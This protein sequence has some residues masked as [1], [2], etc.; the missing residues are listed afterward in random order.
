MLMT[1]KKQDNSS[2]LGVLQWYIQDSA[3]EMPEVQRCGMTFFNERITT[4]LDFHEIFETWSRYRVVDDRKR[5]PSCHPPWNS[6]RTL[7]TR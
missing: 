6:I 3:E 2:G 1:P 4:L 7:R 5:L